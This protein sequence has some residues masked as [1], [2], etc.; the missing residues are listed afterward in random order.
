MMRVTPAGQNENCSVFF[1]FFFFF[2]TE[3]FSRAQRT[4]SEHEF[5][6]RVARDENFANNNKYV[7][8]KTFLYKV[9][10]EAV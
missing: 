7:A 2:L 3:K 8:N 1:F 4:G 9:H 6:S 10:R 5:P